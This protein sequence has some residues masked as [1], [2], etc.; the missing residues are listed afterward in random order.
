VTIL[1]KV[2]SVA[3]AQASHPALII[4]AKPAANPPALSAPALGAANAA[5]PP[6][7][8]AN[9]LQILS[10][11]PAASDARLT[12]I[13]QD[14]PAAT[15]IQFASLAQE[16]KD[17]LIATGL[18][19][20]KA[21]ISKGSIDAGTSP[22]SSLLDADIAEQFP[23]KNA[24]LP[25]RNTLGFNTNIAAPSGL[26][27]QFGV[28][29][30]L[31]SFSDGQSQTVPSLLPPQIPTQIEGADDS[32]ALLHAQISDAKG[33]DS[34]HLAPPELIDS[35]PANAGNRA[36]PEAKAGASDAP[37]VLA[38]QKAALNAAAAS[39]KQKNGGHLSANQPQDDEPVSRGK[40][41][42][43]A[44]SLAALDGKTLPQVDA[45]GLPRFEGAI[46][47]KG[48][49]VG[50][51]NAQNGSDN[52]EALPR[53]PSPKRNPLPHL[54]TV[55]EEWDEAAQRL[56]RSEFAASSSSSR[57]D[58]SVLSQSAQTQSLFQQA[59]APANP[60]PLASASPITATATQATMP[61][62]AVETSIDR[63]LESLINTLSE[64][65]E[66]G[67]A[68]RGDMQLRHADFGTVSLGLE[69]REGDLRALLSSRDPGFAPAAQAALAERSITAGSEGQSA[70]SRSNDQSSG[71]SSGQA[72][73]QTG[74]QNPGFGQPR[75]GERGFDN[76]TSLAAHD[77]EPAHAADARAS[78][79]DPQMTKTR[80]AQAGATDLMA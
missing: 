65:R 33:S 27:R 45:A 41:L 49:D 23:A 14:N 13:G 40:T 67:R 1:A 42:P 51:A 52:Q 10:E 76:Q 39:L 56:A 72:Q 62:A 6:Q 59:S 4:A 75:G 9:G 69:R 24:V 55:R 17:A 11:S 53:N 16:A 77:D 34:A 18:A 8:P 58:G 15:S 64:A 79:T 63:K 32:G 66:N 7:N 31:S 78:D 60:A 46:V 50:S 12:A 44:A 38:D 74:G 37:E 2:N 54:S 3:S 25:D 26:A 36:N 70:G 47:A 57:T 73:N 61:D 28:N 20:S 19:V 35:L 48:S 80:N 68:A 22:N 43:N 29:T 21:R 30:D 71:Q 5:A